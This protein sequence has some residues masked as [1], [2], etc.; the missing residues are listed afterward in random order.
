MPRH[1]VHT[2]PAEP[3]EPIIPD[4]RDPAVKVPLALEDWLAVSVLAVL[5]LIT[6][7]N[8]LVRYFTDQSFAWTEEISVFLLIVLTMAGGSSAFVRNHHIRIEAVADSG[9]PARQRRLAI[10]SHTVVLLFFILLTVLSAR[11]VLDEYMY[12]ET[13]PAIGVPTW[14]YSIWLPAMAAAIALRTLGTLR[15]LLQGKT[16]SSPPCFSSSSPS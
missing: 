15:R 7:G 11:L 5:A 12:E 8:V 1:D 3:G 2:E 13:S 4:E 9:S 16:Q 10:I 14:W 6:F